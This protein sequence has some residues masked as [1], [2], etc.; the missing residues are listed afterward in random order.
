MLDVSILGTP[1][2]NTKVSLKYKRDLFVNF[3]R[4]Y[5]IFDFAFNINKRGLYY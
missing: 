3:A 1:S 2:T 4:I 5:S